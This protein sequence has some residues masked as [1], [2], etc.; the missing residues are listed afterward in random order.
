MNARSACRTEKIYES[1]GMCF[2]FDARVLACEPCPQGFAVELDRTAF[3]PEGGGQHA[4]VGTLN[5][6]R[7]L[8]VRQIGDRILH[9]LEAPFPAD[10]A[11]HGALDAGVRL[12][13]MQH[14]TGEHI[15]SGLAHRMWG[16][17]NVGF[18]L[19]DGEVTADFDVELTRDQLDA[20][21]DEA[22]RVVWRDVAVRAEY[23]DAATLAHLSY[24]SKLALTEGVRIVT[25]EGVD[26][27]ACC[28][29]H[30]A[31]TGQI[32]LIKILSGIRY[33]SGTR[34]FLACGA[35]ALADYREKY[36]TVDA[37]AVHFSVR[38]EGVSGAVEKLE[39]SL[40]ATREK[41]AALR[42]D[43]AER[44]LIGA[45]PDAQGNLLIFTED[46]EDAW[47]RRLS[48]EGAARCPG[49]CA[50][51]SG[52]DG[53]WRYVMASRHVPLREFA[54]R[55]HSACRGKGGGKDTMVQGS[56]GASH[57]EIAH[58]FSQP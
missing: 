28:A 43:A 2:S 30:V 55:F 58:F 3:F 54:V 50:V 39:E 53:Q 51:F 45:E 42:R 16:C 14:H 33:K 4:D 56:L 18:H 11:V 24:R 52:T 57:A 21:E 7:V 1:D 34:I 17:N 12:S 6:A 8:D 31:R 32:G 9:I 20:L 49:I 15:V 22:N 23:P 40:S 27:C 13:R 41:Y 44:L 38:H 10:K 26:A 47:L 29:P 36:R 46:L 5:G 48:D 25:V 37:L 19:G 35:R